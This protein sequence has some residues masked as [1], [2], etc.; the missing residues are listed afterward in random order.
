MTRSLLAGTGRAL[1]A[2]ATVW[3]LLLAYI[4]LVFAVR[5]LLLPAASQDDAEQLVFAQTLAGGYNP[6]QPPLYT[7]LVR[8]SEGIFGPTILAVAAVKFACLGLIY[9]FLYLTAREVFGNRP[10]DRLDAALAGLS[11]LALYYVAFDA[12]FNYSNTMVMA[13]ACAGTLY[14]LVRVEKSGSTLAYGGLGLAVGLGLMSKYGYGVFIAALIVACLAEPAFRARLLS[15]RLLLSLAVAVLVCLPHL[16]WLVGGGVDLAGALE[17][18]LS[19]VDEGGYLVRVGTGLV[20]LGNAVISFLFPLFIVWLVLFPRAWR[21][22]PDVPPGSA[23]YKRLF[24][25]FF[26]AAVALIAAGIV[27]FGITRV[28]N[29]YMFILLAAPIYFFIR[30]RAAGVGDLPRQIFAVFLGVAT[31]AFVTIV[32]ARFLSGPQLSKKPYFNVP[33]A[34]LAQQI[35]AGGFTRGTIVAGFRRYQ[36]GGNFRVHFPGSR[37]LSTKYPY[38]VPPTP[39]S[40]SRVSPGK[41]AGQCLLVWDASYGAAVPPSLRDYARKTLGVEPGTWDRPRIVEAPFLRSKTRRLKLG[42]LLVTG[43]TG[44]CR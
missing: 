23:K 3:L 2:P 15:V 11:P 12:L 25:V 42:T 31:V 22:L 35:R 29:H 21:R 7:W 16:I 6:S 26:I 9:V 19:G 44:R 20:K 33:Y 17:A 27:I 14:A 5:V 13:A 40:S 43:K 38:Y 37:V 1:A 4:A 34:A 28:R 8:L 10:G 41:P 18:R 32:F 24:E 30:V 39:A 36:I